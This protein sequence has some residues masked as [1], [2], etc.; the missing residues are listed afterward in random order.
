[1][2]PQKRGFANMPDEQRRVVSSM[3][4]KAAHIKGTAHRW[5]SEQA[6]EAGSKGGK[7]THRKRL[8]L[9]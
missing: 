3:G 1:M 7:A 8:E 2:S 4:G 9:P 6:R 5:T